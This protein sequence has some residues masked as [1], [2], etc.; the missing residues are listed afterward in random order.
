MN[1]HIIGELAAFGT[2]QA[3]MTER[4][5]TGRDIL[6]LDVDSVQSF[7]LPTPSQFL[8]T[9]YGSEIWPGIHIFGADPGHGKTTLMVHLMLEYVKVGIPVIF[10]ETEL[11]EVIFYLRFEKILK[12][13]DKEL[14]DLFVFIFGG[15]N[16]GKVENV[17]KEYNFQRPPLL[18]MDI[19]DALIGL[20]DDAR[21]SLNYVYS[22][23]AMMQLDRLVS[24]VFTTSHLVRGMK[25][26]DRLA[27]TS[28]KNRIASSVVEFYADDTL[29]SDDLLLIT[30]TLKKNRF[31]QAQ[32]T[33]Q[34]LLDVKT[35]SIDTPQSSPSF[36]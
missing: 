15:V 7:I 35:L 21:K 9:L 32:K 8:K 6:Q 19:P 12:S 27:E 31:G 17:I 36:L 14:L 30:A 2:T 25:E 26:G 5:F 20:F 22:Q 23:L 28:F 34:F 18:I 16:V 1:P 4:T 33:A 10:V 3:L 11:T 13:V 24:S 29:R